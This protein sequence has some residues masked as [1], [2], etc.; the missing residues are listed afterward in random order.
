MRVADVDPNADPK[1]EA[2]PY[3]THWEAD[4]VLRDGAT[5]HLRPINPEDAGSLE[6]FHAGQSAESIYLRYFA[7]MPR[8]S[9]R[10]VY[11]FTHVD[12][13]DRVAFV[14]TLGEAIVGVA[15]L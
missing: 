7:P 13:V 9:A 8:L 15:K 12:H 2:R 3:P 5:A 11:R 10:D 6:R 14:C 1:G 4:V